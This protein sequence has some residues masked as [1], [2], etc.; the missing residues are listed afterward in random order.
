MGGR[1]VTIVA[2]FQSRAQLL[3][4]YGDADAAV[5]L[6]NA[7]AVLLFGG[8]RDRDDLKFWSTLAGER[9]EPVLS[10]DLHGVA[11]TRTVRKMPVMAPRRPRTCPPVGWWRSAGDQPRPRAGLAWPGSAAT[12]APCSPAT[13]RGG[14][15][16]L[17]PLARRLARLRPPY[18]R[19]AAQRRPGWST[20][21]RG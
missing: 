10:T 20:T 5:I 12:S 3:A 11:G 7:A 16:L 1:G 8:T 14:R 2:A 15:G 18:P 4:R 6:N 9:D 21:T 19:P 17:A 13:S